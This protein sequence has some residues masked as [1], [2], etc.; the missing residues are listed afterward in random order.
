MLA[1]P[2]FPLAPFG[3]AGMT[4]E[5]AGA[6]ALLPRS[7]EDHG[8]GG[9]LRRFRLGRGGLRFCFLCAGP[10]AAVGVHRVVV[11]A[12]GELGFVE[13]VIVGERAHFA[14]LVI[15]R[16]ADLEIAVEIGAEGLRE[17][18]GGAGGGWWLWRS[19]S[20]GRVTDARSW[21]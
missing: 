20:S 19:W 14:E 3:L 7:G 11:V 12:A 15:L 16:D 10:Q 21:W 9:A 2:G 4:A 8:G 1:A 18:V 6:G 17:I 5:G 13:A